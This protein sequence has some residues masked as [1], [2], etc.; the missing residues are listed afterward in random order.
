M[1]LFLCIGVL[2][3][4]RLF[5]RTYISD[6][7]TVD[8]FD[9]S[10]DKLNFLWS[11]GIHHKDS[12]ALSKTESHSDQ[13]NINNDIIWVRMGSDGNK[14]DINR[15]C[16][17]LHK[18][19][20]S[21][22]LVTSDGDMSIPSDLKKETF[23]TIISNTNIIAWY[24]QNYDGTVN[25]P[26]LKHYPIGLDIHTVCRP[27]NSWRE[28]L[29]PDNGPVER[30]NTLLKTRNITDTKINRVLCDVH[31]SPN[32]KFNN[33]RQRVY[34]IL[35]DKEH[36]DFLTSRMIQSKISKNYSEYKYIISTHGN[37][38]DCHRT[39]E[40]ILLGGIVVTK[41]SSLDPLFKGLPVIILNDWN[42]CTMENLAAHDKHNTDD[43]LNAFTYNHWLPPINKLKKS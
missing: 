32:K 30:I 10:G 35:K 17:V 25:H 40:I 2:V 41:T 37:G 14:T 22:I 28:F 4:S 13:F 6:T 8:Y 33:E 36:V 1:L 5:N 9:K 21:K 15:F 19:T 26:K 29:T 31:L 11:K 7:A 34:D 39:W 42:E 43:I 27:K 18:L 12:Y 38:L 3:Y 20:T 24:T 23:D 16:D